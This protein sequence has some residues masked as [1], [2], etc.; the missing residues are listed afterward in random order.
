MNRFKNGKGQCALLLGN[1]LMKLSNGCL[2]LGVESLSTDVIE[3][4]TS[5]RVYVL[6]FW[7]VFKVR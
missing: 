4:Q 6:D 1:T 5:T 7:H 2:D 3:Q